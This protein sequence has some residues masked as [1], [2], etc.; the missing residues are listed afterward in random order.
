VPS[1]MDPEEQGLYELF[2]AVRTMSIRL[3]R[4]LG[5]G[6]LA[7]SAEIEQGRSSGPPLTS[8]L[9]GVLVQALNLFGSALA[10]PTEPERGG[11]RGQD[12]EPQ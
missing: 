5:D 7:A 12:D 2:A 6:V 11:S 1:P 8:V 10:G 9:T 3:T 4:S